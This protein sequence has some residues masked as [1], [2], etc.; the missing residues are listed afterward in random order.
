MCRRGPF[1]G[2]LR[3]RRCGSFRGAEAHSQPPSRTVVAVGD[4]ESP[5]LLPADGV[6]EEMSARLCARNAAGDIPARPFGFLIGSCPRVTAGVSVTM[7]YGSRGL[8]RPGTLAPLG[9]VI[10]AGL[11]PGRSPLGMLFTSKGRNGRW[12]DS[13]PYQYLGCG[14][15]QVPFAKLLVRQKSE[16]RRPLRRGTSPTTP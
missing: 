1:N 4:P 9:V 16:P 6:R 2:F 10:V 7:G 8:Y 5:R 11:V 15:R 13:L 14:A 12:S 3:R